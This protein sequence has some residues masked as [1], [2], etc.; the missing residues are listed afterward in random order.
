MRHLKKIFL[1]AVL[2]LFIL[3]ACSADKRVYRKGYHITW[4]HH[5]QTSPGQQTGLSTKTSGVAV[6][7]QVLHS[8]AASIVQQAHTETKIILS[9][10]QLFPVEVASNRSSLPA[11]LSTPLKRSETLSIFHKKPM[12]PRSPS[13][14]YSQIV[15]LLLCIFVG[16]VGA[17]RFYLGYTT[18]GVLMIFTLGGCGIWALID[19]I[20]ILTGDLQPIDGP[21]SETL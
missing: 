13:G 9:S 16:I 2:A 8:E 1:F 21:Y 20:R 11:Q 4:L 3:S 17:H 6:K 19:L 7:A 10:T 12:Q 15:A 5:K 18:L 14:G